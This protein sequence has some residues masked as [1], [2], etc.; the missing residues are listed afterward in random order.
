MEELWGLKSILDNNNDISVFIV[1]KRQYSILY[2]NHLF[3]IKTGKHQ[4]DNLG[5]VWDEAYGVLDKME[6]GRTV[7]FVSTSSPFGKCNNITVTQIVWSKGIKAYAFV[8][9]N[10]LESQEELDNAIIFST[11]GKAYRSM[12]DLNINTR[13]VR[14]LIA[15]ANQDLKIYRPT[16][17]NA[18]IEI[19]ITNLIHNDDREDACRYFEF[20]NI[21]K[22]TE[23]NGDYSFQVRTLY[24]DQEYHWMEYRFTR[25]KL[26]DS[27]EHIVCYQRDIHKE[28][29]VNRSNLENEMILKSLTNNYRSIYLLDLENG[30]YS[31][32]KPDKLL[33][34]IPNEGL[35]SELLQIVEELIRDDTQKKDLVEYF[36]IEAL[37]NAFKEGKDNIGREYSSNLAK[38]LC[39]L[40]ISAFKAPQIPSLQNKCIITFM[41][42]TEHKRVEVERDESAL[43]LNILSSRYI[44]VY[45]A[46]LET[47]KYHSLRAPAQ[48]NH[49]EQMGTIEEGFGQYISCYVQE[50]YKEALRKV[51]SLDYLRSITIDNQEEFVYKTINNN[52]VRM[53]ISR[54]P[55]VEGMDEVLVAFE[56]YE[57]D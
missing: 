50:E 20:N 33:F 4:G 37:D 31:T 52:G 51:V 40:S 46:D 8:I 34:G 39:W 11:L 30:E 12:Y 10:H 29:I 26:T 13:E 57:E 47:G 24:P 27:E 42:V 19:L 17:Y 15:P 32:V 44:A 38:D 14:M 9:T 55:S 48:Y 23:E 16:S 2:C 25:V 21:L 7:R 49:L 6:D 28:L 53:F 3:T 36:S 1:E 18:V 22:M 56:P 5:N 54:I 35:Y 45:F 43:A 41:D